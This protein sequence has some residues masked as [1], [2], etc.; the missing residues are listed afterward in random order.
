MY[1]PLARFGLMGALLSLRRRSRVLCVH[2][3]GARCIGRVSATRQKTC[4][5]AANRALV[6][7]SDSK[8]RRQ[9]VAP[10][11]HM[12]GSCRQPEQEPCSCGI[13]WSHSP[14]P[15]HSLTVHE[16][17]TT[18]LTIVDFEEALALDW[19][20]FDWDR[21]CLAVH[22]GS[23]KIVGR[24]KSHPGIAIASALHSTGYTLIQKEIANL[25]T[26][27]AEGIRTIRYSHQMI[28]IPCRHDRSV[29]AAGYLMQYFGEETA[30]VYE[31]GDPGTED[32]VI[33]PMRKLRV[34]Q[35]DE[36]IWSMNRDTIRILKEYHLENAFMEDL[37]V[38]VKLM[39]SKHVR[40]NDFQGFLGKDGHFYVADPLGLEPIRRPV[41]K[42]LLD[43]VFM[44]SEKPPRKNRP[45]R[46]SFVDALGVS[47]GFDVLDTDAA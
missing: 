29:K 12:C 38:Y 11:T 45:S 41:N 28:E 46:Q 30:F 34:V 42:N 6:S 9:V 22:Q 5:S 47:L 17:R 3:S 2:C 40:I 14:I 32:H 10:E 31:E 43:G 15:Q 39:M 26:L 13:R 20:N 44:H 25:D 16:R 4:S 27:A 36:G 35:D 33:E 18:P 19:S 21:D 1:G 8:V 7:K 23:M 37:A 24:L